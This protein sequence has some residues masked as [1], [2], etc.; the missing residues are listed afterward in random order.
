MHKKDK[1]FSKFVEF[2]AL[3]EKETNKK[4]KALRSDNGGEYVVNGLRLKQEAAERAFQAS[5]KKD[6]TIKRLKELR[7][8]A[9]STKDLSDDNAFWMT[10]KKQIKDKLWAEMQVPDN[11]ADDSEEYFF[12]CFVLFII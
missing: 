2:K 5:Q 3:V 8:L 1:T 12:I 6:N 10:N 9:L 7:F 4:V 11:Q